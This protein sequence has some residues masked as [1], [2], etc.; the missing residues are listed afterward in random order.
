MTTFVHAFN[1]PAV[2]VKLQIR[3]KLGINFTQTYEGK[4]VRYDK[5]YDYASI[6]LANNKQFNYNFNN[7]K[8]ECKQI[9]E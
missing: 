6:F 9:M 7:K 1:V 2:E 4:C 5:V 8:I 3:V